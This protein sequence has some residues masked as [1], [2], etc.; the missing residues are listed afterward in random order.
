MKVTE[1]RRACFSR[2][3]MA[4]LN[5]KDSVSKCSNKYQRLDNNQNE[6]LFLTSTSHTSASKA[7]SD[8]IFQKLNNTVHLWTLAFQDCKL[9]CWKDKKNIIFDQQIE[10]WGHETETPQKQRRHSAAWTEQRNWRPLNRVSLLRLKRHQRPIR[11]DNTDFALCIPLRQQS[12]KNRGTIAKQL[13][14]AA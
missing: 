6:L 10:I 14:G 12:E 2:M 3:C 5:T 11:D 4:A 7:Y 9:E 1:I 13:S 8:K